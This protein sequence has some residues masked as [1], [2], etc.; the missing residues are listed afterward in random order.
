MFFAVLCFLY[1]IMDLTGKPTFLT[2]Y[3]IQDD[4]PVMY[5]FTKKILS[6]IFCLDWS[7]KIQRSCYKSHFEYHNLQLATDSSVLLCWCVEGLPVWLRRTT[8]S[9]HCCMAVHCD[10]S[11]WGIGLLLLAQ[12]EFITRTGRVYDGMMSSHYGSGGTLIFFEYQNVWTSC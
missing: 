5:A 2:K 3:K 12:V 1:A 10:S 7:R 9:V 8:R 4:Q 6:S 11:G